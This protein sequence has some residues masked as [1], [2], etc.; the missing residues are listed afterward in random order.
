MKIGD[1]C[2]RQV[3]TAL[4]TATLVDVARQMRNQHV[5]SVVIVDESRRPV[6]IITDRDIVIETVACNVDARMLAAGEVMSAGP[7]LANEDDDSAWALKIMRD[8]GVRRLPVVDA[9]GS[10]VGIVALDDLLE[11]TATAFYDVVQAIGTE[12]LQEGQRRKVAA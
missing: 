3:V 1:A 5:G 2:K 9:K 10:L 6:G 11:S 4:A 8:R 7:T 12:R